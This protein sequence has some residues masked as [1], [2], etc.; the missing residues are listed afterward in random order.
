MTFIWPVVGPVSRDFYYR[1]SI[2]IGGQHGAIDIPAS[3][4]TPIKP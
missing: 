2:Y 1:A 3:L 4:G